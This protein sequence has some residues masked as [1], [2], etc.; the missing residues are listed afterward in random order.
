MDK[1]CLPESQLPLEF[2]SGHNAN[3]AVK[4]EL[5]VKWHSVT[6]SERR[7]TTATVLQKL[8]APLVSI[9]TLPTKPWSV[10]ADNYF[11]AQRDAQKDIHW[12][13][14]CSRKSLCGICPV[15]GKT[16]CRFISSLQGKLHKPL[17]KMQTILRLPAPCN[18]TVE[19]SPSGG[20]GFERGK[21]KPSLQPFSL[22]RHS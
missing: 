13:T 8:A 6:T 16:G 5:G 22:L 3:K 18:G 17:A 19:A 12:K 1:L 7:E 15:K 9:G 14:L 4:G 20:T 21:L 11:A 10:S 2:F